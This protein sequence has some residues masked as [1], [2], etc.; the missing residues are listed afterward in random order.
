MNRRGCF[1]TVLG[2]ATAANAETP[3]SPVSFGSLVWPNEGR[4]QPGIRSLD[5]HTDTVLDVVG[6]I[7]TPASL[8]IFTEGNH[9]MVLSS[10]DIIGGFPSWAKL[11]PQSANRSEF[12][13]CLMWPA[14]V[15]I[16][17]CPMRVIFG[18]SVVPLAVMGLSG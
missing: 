6:R 13:V 12:M 4:S 11:Q 10:A 17:R 16:S 9:L 1:G 18:P 5:G 14:R 15:S 7:G 2:F 3:A 8:V